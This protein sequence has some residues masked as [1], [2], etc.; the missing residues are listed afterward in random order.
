MKY[1]KGQTVILLQDRKYA[2]GDQ[3]SAG[4]SGV[5]LL[6]YPMSTS[7]LVMFDKAKAPHRIA[8]PFLSGK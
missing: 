3:I 4:T 8:E 6:E 5:I 1:K 2:N 7:Y